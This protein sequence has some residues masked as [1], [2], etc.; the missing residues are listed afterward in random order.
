MAVNGEFL[1]YSKVYGGKPCPTKVKVSR[2]EAVA[3]GWHRAASLFGSDIW[4]N[5]YKYYKL[6]KAELQI[7]HPNRIFGRLVPIWKSR[8]FRLAWVIDFG[9][10]EEAGEEKL[11]E[12]GFH[13]RMLYK[14]DAATG[15]VIGGSD[16]RCR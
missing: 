12:L 6:R 14:I 10:A 2:E 4:K 13:H 7:V 15:K 8:D 5:N 3:K 1:G 11:M 16:G 9:L